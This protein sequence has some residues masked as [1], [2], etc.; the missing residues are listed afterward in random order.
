MA[1][2]ISARSQEGQ[3]ER[4]AIKLLTIAAVS[5]FEAR[6]KRLLQLQ[7]KLFRIE[8]VSAAELHARAADEAKRDQRQDKGAHLLFLPAENFKDADQC[9]YGSGDCGELLGVDSK[10]DSRGKGQQARICAFLF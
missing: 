7:E 10:A 8:S 1:M 5:L 6:L 9:H 4:P 2:T 3:R